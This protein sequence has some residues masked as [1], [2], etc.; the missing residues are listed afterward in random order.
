MSAGD[1]PA[2]DLA[3][4]GF[5][6]HRRLFWATDWQTMP[7]VYCTAWMSDKGLA[8]TTGRANHAALIGALTET[9]SVKFV[10]MSVEGRSEK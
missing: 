1:L 10:G 6:G 8:S 4:D 5:G 7:S 2:D 3:K 9:G